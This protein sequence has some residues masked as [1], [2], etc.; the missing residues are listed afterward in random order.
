[1]MTMT[2]RR[3][4]EILDG[5]GDLSLC[6]VGDAYIDRYYDIDPRLAEKSLETFRTAHQAVATRCYPGGAGNVAKDLR[7]FGVGKVF[8]L[9]CI[10]TDGRGFELKKLFDRLGVDRSPTLERE[11]RYTPSFV[12]PLFHE[13]GKPPREP[14]RFDVRTRRNLPR[15]ADRELV[16]RL[17]RIAKDVAGIVVVDQAPEAQ[18]GVVTARMRRKA[19]ELGARFP[20]KVIFVDSR[21]RIG[22]FRNA[23]LKPA[24]REAMAALGMESKRPTLKRIREA[25]LALHRRARR[26]I[27]ATLG[28]KGC[29]CVADGAVTRVPTYRPSGPLDIVG[30][31]DSF[32]TGAVSALCRGASPVEAALIG[33]LAASITVEQLG[34]TGQA[35]RSQLRRRLREF[36]RQQ[37]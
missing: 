12:K 36:V 10:G 31:G 35:T 16:R 19:T 23:M 24:A 25:A 26:P 28:E 33:N 15:D 21:R 11:D 6:V 17:D 27:F 18:Y 32:T 8:V 14:E 4:N 37:G 1:M 13:P 22:K 30:A 7:A 29:F 2:S 34:V 5:V 3:L 20:D 9:S